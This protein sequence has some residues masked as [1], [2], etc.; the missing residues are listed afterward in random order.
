MKCTVG[1][2]VSGNG[3]LVVLVH[4]SASGRRQWRSLPA[5]LED[6]FTVVALD[7]LGYGD[8]P[9]WTEPRPQQLSDQSALIHAVAEDVGAPLALVGHSFG[10]SVALCAA[11]ELGDRL[12]G[13]I[14]LEPNPF[15]LL[16]E[17]G[18]PEYD[19]AAALRDAVKAA[20]DAGAWPEAAERFA[21]Y[22]NGPGTWQAMPAER[23]DAF[24]RALR[25]NYHEWDAVLAA[26]AA[27]YV[28]AVTASTNV[29]SARDT[30]APIAGIVAILEQL[31]P[32]WTFTRIDSGGHMV[33]LTRPEAVNRVVAGALDDLVARGGQLSSTS[34]AR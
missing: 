4:S 10:A 5:A 27:R 22:W 34:P 24:A 28:A 13:L 20:G 8:T 23:R 2:V 31:R 16:R 21:D 25:P 26:P 15:S 19:E 12:V 32:D 6:R 18:A 1:R 30:V 11:A 29:V 17:A 7:L 3:P 14:L 33:P 9:A